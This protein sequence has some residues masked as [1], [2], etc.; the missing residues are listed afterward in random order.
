MR[1]RIAIALGISAVAVLGILWAR[2]NGGS[3][4]WSYDDMLAHTADRIRDVEWPP[5]LEPTARE[6][7]G[8]E[9]GGPESF[10]SGIDRQLVDH[11][12][13]CAW[14]AAWRR[15]DDN[16]DPAQATDLLA[17]LKDAVATW[18]AGSGEGG[19]APG[20]Q[21]QAIAEAEQGNTS[22]ARGS[23]FSTMCGE[24]TGKWW[25]Q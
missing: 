6:V 14:W 15:A 16:Q 2:S 5:G 10:P 18:A 7:A 20:L 11:D 12:R 8:P 25:E 3:D 13:V 23:A 24:G 21:V 22:G 17:G 19:S 1:I 4:S 9:A